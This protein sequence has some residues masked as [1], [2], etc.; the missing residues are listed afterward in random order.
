MTQL[1]TPDC[2]IPV[3]FGATLLCEACCPLGQ[4]Y[5]DEGVIYFDCPEHLRI[6]FDNGK[7][8]HV[9]SRGLRN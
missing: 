7:V 9:E 5:C 1:V 2:S 4:L 6:T 8:A 3:Y